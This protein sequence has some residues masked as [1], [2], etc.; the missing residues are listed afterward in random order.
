MEQMQTRLLRLAGWCRVVSMV[1]YSKCCV[2]P[3][4]I[5]EYTLEAA[6]AVYDSRFLVSHYA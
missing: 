1:N 4:E 2:N 5:G 6:W 3:G